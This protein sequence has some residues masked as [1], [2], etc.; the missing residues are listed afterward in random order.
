MKKE[1]KKRQVHSVDDAIIAETVNDTNFSDKDKETLF[2]LATRINSEMFEQDI[3]QE[4]LCDYLEISQGALSNYRHGLR[5]PDG[6]VLEKMADKFGTTTDYLLG[7]TNLKSVNKDYQKVHEITGLTDNA[8]KTLE[9]LK[10]IHNENIKANKGNTRIQD[11]F[12]VISYL[13][14]N[15]TK[16]LLFSNIADYLWFDRKHKDLIEKNEAIHDEYGFKLEMKKVS[17][18]DKII[19]ED[20]LLEIKNEIEN[21]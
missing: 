9:T 2:K 7:R 10:I 8:I 1:R 4:D 5:F 3:T 11:T 20:T 6:N 17:T 21:K 12:D 15:E 18:V 19:I 14:E 16:H 13:I